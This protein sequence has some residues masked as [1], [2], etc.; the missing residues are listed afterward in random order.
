MEYLPQIIFLILGLGIGGGAAA[1]IMRERVRRA[2]ALGRSDAESDLR[3][4]AIRLEEAERRAREASDRI[5][6]VSA[7]REMT[8]KEAHDKIT[9]LTAR[10]SQLE[11][12]LKG[13]RTAGQDKLDAWNKA[14]A[15]LTETF[16]ALSSESL[17][18]NNESFMQIA[19]EVLDKHNSSAKGELEKRSEAIDELVKPLRESLKEVGAKIEGL[20]KSRE[21]AY[22][23][24][25]QQIKTLNENEQSLRRETQNLTKALSAPKVRGKWGEI[26]L[27][28]LVELAGLV[29]HCDF[30][31]QKSEKTDGGGRTRPDMIVNLPG[32]KCIVVDSK[33]PLDGFLSALET[34]DEA[35]RE[36]HME[37]H[38]RQV[39]DRVK[40][41]G[42]R[43]YQE[44]FQPTPEF[45]VMFLPYESFFSAALQKDPGLIEM[46]VEERVIIATP[47]TLIAIL[48]AVHYGWRQE[49]LAENARK[50]SDL[51]KELYDRIATMTG[52]ITRL[53]TQLDGAVKAHN[54]MI[55]SIEAKVLSSARRFQDLGA[56]GDANQ[57]PEMKTIHTSSRRIEK[58]EL[59]I[60][61]T[62]DD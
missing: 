9:T 5:A 47:T 12:E 20:E 48:R 24:L 34:K 27:K 44:S 42:K 15:K 49:T 36:M 23:E 19:N 13:E 43:A 41:L 17:K 8:I 29:D 61:V 31:E 3:E 59:L 46:G 37:R 4:S 21:G 40:E 26:G 62:E 11:E 14:E 54:A 58:D 35:E 30:V 1:T 28:R 33:V 2:E 55:G 25:R 22:S 52:H 39:R 45:V 53:G 50:I 16:K 51:G 32:G 10:A 56:V 18:S 38:A 7:Q 6:E 57:I 60:D